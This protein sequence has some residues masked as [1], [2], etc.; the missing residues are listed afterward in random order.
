MGSEG[1]TN[2][3]GTAGPVALGIS[4]NLERLSTTISVV[5]EGMRGVPYI[6][7]EPK[8]TRSRCILVAAIVTMIILGIVVICVV[9][10]RMESV[11]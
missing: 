10:G 8:I 9:E 1:R 11:V 2:G 7:E 3:P 6:L 5:E 4:C